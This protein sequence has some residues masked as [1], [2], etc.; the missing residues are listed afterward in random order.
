MS[1]KD[2]EGKVLEVKEVQS[3]K[4]HPAN[5]IEVGVMIGTFKS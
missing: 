3:N 5:I 4:I 2:F 1:V